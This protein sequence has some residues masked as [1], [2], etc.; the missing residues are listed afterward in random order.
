MLAV[1]TDANIYWE[2]SERILSSDKDHLYM[3]EINTLYVTL[4]WISIYMYLHKKRLNIDINEV[5]FRMCW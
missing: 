4:F 1:F 2:M 5:S 3:T